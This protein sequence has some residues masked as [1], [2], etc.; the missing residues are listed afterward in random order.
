[1]NKWDYNNNVML[2]IEALGQSSGAVVTSIAAV[3]FTPSTGE[4]HSEFKMNVNIQSALNKGLRI[5]GK[6]LEWW[7]SQT[8]EAQKGMLES[9]VAI[10]DVL[11]HFSQW[12]T[13]L[14][15][16]N[17]SIIPWKQMNWWANGANYDFVL[18]DACYDALRKDWKPW[19]YRNL[20]DMRTLRTYTGYKAP[21]SWFNEGVQHDALDDCVRQVRMVKDMIEILRK[22]V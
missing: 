13:K 5:D 19:H 15:D 4:V 1:M 2:D 11:H 20:M 16:E 8:Q 17:K 7:F 22:G 3:Q 12:S 6:T 14:V 18:M 21:D 9:P 10:E